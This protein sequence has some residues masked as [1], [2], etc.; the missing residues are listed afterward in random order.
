[1]NDF[2]KT[3]PV[4]NGDRLMMAVEDILNRKY[5]L[6]ASH[7]PS[8]PPTRSSLR[9]AVRCSPWPLISRMVLSTRAAS[10]HGDT[11]GLATI[12]VLEAVHKLAL[13]MPDHA[14]I[15]GLDANT[16][17]IGS[18]KNQGVTEF[19]QAFRSHGYSSC[20]G[21]APDPVG[22]RDCNSRRLPNQSAGPRRLC[23]RTLSSR[24][25]A[26]P[27]FTD[28]ADDLQRAYLSAAAAA[29]GRQVG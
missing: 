16:Y 17:T 25:C 22:A 9:L 10:F 11:N 12:P 23:A 6:G 21:D 29:K 5:L 4:A 24:G 14:L 20:W 15:F 3:E 8:S 2:D 28:L 26:T 18:A 19:A 1:M 13:T 27:M 7:V